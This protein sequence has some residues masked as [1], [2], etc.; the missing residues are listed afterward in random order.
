[1]A[2]KMKANYSRSGSR[3]AGI[4]P[5]PLS[6]VR[7][8]QRG[9]NQAELLAK[10]LGDD[11]NVEVFSI[12]KRVKE[13]QRQSEMRSRE[14]RQRNVNGAFELDSDFPL[15]YFK[16]K[17]LILVDDVLT[18]GFTMQVCAKSFRQAGLNIS[19]LVVAAGHKDQVHNAM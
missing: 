14:E 5:M 19:G 1:M 12:A 4:V 7:Y 10:H 13:T 6:P 16:G 18:S 15:D 2:T 8:R 11:I 9:Y 3:P 17:Q